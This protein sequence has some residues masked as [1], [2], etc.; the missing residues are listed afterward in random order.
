MFLTA[1]KP[2][3]FLGKLAFHTLSLC[4]IKQFRVCCVEQ[5]LL[6]CVCGKCVLW[7]FCC[8]NSTDNMSETKSAAGLPTRV[9]ELSV[10]DVQLFSVV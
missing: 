9:N 10:L 7:C 4:L 1:L 3:D 5:S 6:V 2:P 8:M